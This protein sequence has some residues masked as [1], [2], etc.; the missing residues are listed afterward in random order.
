VAAAVKLLAAVRSGAD[1]GTLKKSVNRLK[2]GFLLCCWQM[3]NFLQAPHDFK[4]QFVCL[5]V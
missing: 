3:L 5:F 2:Q 1:T 4:A